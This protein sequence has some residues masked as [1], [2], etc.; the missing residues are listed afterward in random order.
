MGA[1][2]SERQRRLSSNSPFYFCKQTDKVLCNL[3]GISY[4]CRNGYSRVSVQI[5]ENTVDTA[6]IFIC[7]FVI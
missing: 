7:I 3:L 6:P 2:A 5:K 4:V 1:I